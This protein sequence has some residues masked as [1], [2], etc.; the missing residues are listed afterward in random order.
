MNKKTIWVTGAS[1]GIGRELAKSYIEEGHFVVVSGRNLEAL[2][3]LG[4]L[5][6]DRVAVLDFDLADPAA[7][8]ALPSR[9]ADITDHLDILV[10]AAGTC[11]YV[12]D[13]SCQDALYRR[14]METN[15]F[16]Q[17]HCYL[18]VL[19]LLKRSE[20]RAQIVGIGSLAAYLAFPRAQ[21]YGAS[22]AA[23]EY[24]LNSMRIDLRDQNIDVTVVS[25]GFVDT[26]LTRKNDFS[27]PTLMTVEK[28]N[29][30][31]LKGIS[32]R[33]RH[34]RFPRTLRWTL[35]LMSVFSGIWYEIV[36]PKLSR[37]K[38]L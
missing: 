25:P 19:P 36:S 7:M 35:A 13:P 29:S 9:F 5:A 18:A 32:A 8:Q 20:Q 12:N 16:A 15:Y 17:I 34:V 27:M 3:S 31:I 4:K 2:R 11:E 14:V 30:I 22:K 24:W 38:Q 33:K 28:A 23:F 21:A 1:S 26:P 6:A 37:D 10:L